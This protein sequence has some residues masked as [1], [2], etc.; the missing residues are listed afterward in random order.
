[1]SD[2]PRFVLHF[3]NKAAY[4]EYAKLD[5]SVKRLVDMGYRK[6]MERADEIGKPLGGPLAGCKELKYRKHGIRII[7]KIG[8]DGGVD[9][10]DIV[11]TEKRADGRVFSIA[12]KRLRESPS[13]EV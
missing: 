6:L 7:F 9:I 2:A 10:V 8:E 3:Y 4:K 13:R 5:A 1:M 11:A 12:E